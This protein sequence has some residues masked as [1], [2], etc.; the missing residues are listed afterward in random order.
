MA[1]A[2]NHN[3]SVPLDAD[4]FSMNNFN[5]SNVQF[6][7]LVYDGSVGADVARGDDLSVL[8]PVWRIGIALDKWYGNLHGVE[9]DVWADTG[10]IR[11]VQEIWSSMTPQEESILASANVSQVA[12]KSVITSTFSISG[13]GGLA[14]GDLISFM[15]MTAVFSSATVCA[16][17]VLIRRQKDALCRLRNKFFSKSVAESQFRCNQ[18]WRRVFCLLLL[19]VLLFSSVVFLVRVPAVKAQTQSVG[20][21]VW[22]S[23]STASFNPNIPPSGSSW[24]KSQDEVVAQTAVAENIA[25]WF[26]SSGYGGVLGGVNHQG[27]INYGSYRSSILLGLDYL[28]SEYDHVA[29]VDFDHGVG[30][31]PN[32]TSSQHKLDTA[33]AD[34]WHYQIEDESGEQVGQTRP[35]ELYTEN[36]VYDI[37]ICGHT[38]PDEVTF[39]FINT[40]L[41]ANIAILDPNHQ[42]VAQGPIPDTNRIEGMAFAFT[43]RWVEPKSTP[44]FNIA[45]DSSHPGNVGDI[46]SDGYSDP[47]SG[48]QVYIGFT[49]GS[50]SLSQMI[51]AYPYYYW[52]EEFFAEALN[53]QATMSVHQAL[54]TASVLYYGVNFALSPLRIGF[55]PDWPMYNFTTYEWESGNQDPGTMA[56]YGNGDISIKNAQPTTHYVTGISAVQPY[57]GGWV[58]NPESVEGANDQNYAT[59]YGTSPSDGGAIDCVLD[60][61]TYDGDVHITCYAPYG[62][63]FNSYL[64]VFVSSD[65]SN[66][67]LMYS[68]WLYNTS[69]ADIDLGVYQGMTIRYIS[70]AGWYPDSFCCIAIDSITV[71]GGG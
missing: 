18:P 68:N 31:A 63:Y 1:V 44:G 35:G 51:W 17:F 4:A 53:T 56:V 23:E 3:W 12:P 45:Y 50:A 48:S 34:E 27:T 5:L 41:S 69:P 15:A 62:G 20:A 37:D 70:V 10:Q 32:S 60:S 47:D 9:V 11:S 26:G 16:F 57:G 14:E 38:L 36:A 65:N 6:A 21:A 59:I 19:F 67:Y 29:V 40:C 33:P 46:S 2:Q 13:F 24:R 25:S 7:S 30:N 71:V 42:P 54:D 43:H 8:Y 66:W 52:V 64:W 28:L 22:G 49:Y 58:D 39:A 61:N 55:Y